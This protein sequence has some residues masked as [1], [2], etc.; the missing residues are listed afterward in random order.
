MNVIQ[1]ITDEMARADRRYG[2]YASSH[3]GLGVL[4]EE[5]AELTEAIRRN[6]VS[7]IRLEAI[8]VASVAARLAQCTTDKSFQQRSGFST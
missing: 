5:V 1:S 6:D 8:Q 7:A 3:E 2:P 4:T